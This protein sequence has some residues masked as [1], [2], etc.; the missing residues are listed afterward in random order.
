MRFEVRCS[1]SFRIRIGNRRVSMFV[2][3]MLAVDFNEL[4]EVFPRT[5]W[6]INYVWQTFRTSAL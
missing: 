3:P 1:H 2:R 6:L 5:K 4:A